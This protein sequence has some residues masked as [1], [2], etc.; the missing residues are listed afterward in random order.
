MKTLAA[1]TTTFAVITAASAAHAAGIS[2][3][4]QS[5][6]AT[7]M[8]TAVTGMI[9]DS[10]GIF[11]NPAGIARGRIIDAQISDSLIMPMVTFKDLSGTSTTTPFSVIPPF[12]TYIAGGITD[13]LS[14]GIGM[15][16]PYGL[17]VGWPGGWEGRSLITY[18]ALASYYINPTLAYSI[19]PLRI[20]AGVQV[21]YSTVDLK[22]DIA[23]PGGSFGATELGASTWGIGGNV[24]IQLDI[25]P[26]MLTFGA[27]YR[28]AVEL[29][30]DGNAHFDGIPPTLSGTLHDQP[31]STRIVLPDTFAFGLAIR[32]TKKLVIDL[33]AVYYGWNHFR[34]IDIN[35][36]NDASGT[37]SSTQPKNWS[38]TVNVHL[39]AEY[40]IND[41]WR[42]RGGAFYDPT[43]SPRETLTPDTPD[44]SRV[45]FALGATY[46]HKSGVHVDL[47]Y[48]LVVII[49]QESTAPQLPG[50]YSGFANIVGLAVGYTSKAPP[51]PPA[52]Q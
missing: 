30:F 17:T 27:H 13:H 21:V 36:P 25:V 5:A 47:G 3:D 51:P 16:E 28:S 35:F 12:Q 20:G 33:D 45:N 31:G 8:A 14:A 18:A 42:V 41:T 22:R 40:A 24:G 48:E 44:G 7:G 23:L 10:S 19:G 52:K 50:T 26:D 6:R 4:V 37:L 9:D 29:D 46:K 1:L 38:S 2:V 49:P 11:Y 32:P 43:P 34:S 15:F 39:G